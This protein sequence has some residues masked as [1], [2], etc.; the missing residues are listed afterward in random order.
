MRKF[1]FTIIIFFIIVLFDPLAL[2]GSFK[3]NY[4]GARPLAL[5]GAFVGLADD[6][7]AMLYNPAGI[8][9][10]NHFEAIVEYINPYGVD[11]LYQNTGLVVFNTKIFGAV[12]LGADILQYRDIYKEFA[13]ILSY[14]KHISEEIALGI[15]LKY[16]D[17]KIEGNFGS[18]PEY[19]FSQKLGV[20]IAALINVNQFISMGMTA[21]NMNKPSILKEEGPAYVKFGFAAYPLMF[22]SSYFNINI[23]KLK[24]KALV[25]T[26]D[27]FKESFV[28]EKEIY[29]K[30]I[31]GIEYK[32]N[33]SWSIRAG[34][35]YT[36]SF[37][38]GIGFFVKN[39]VFNYCFISQRDVINNNQIFSAGIKL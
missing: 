29:T 23:K 15:N 24:L 6:V 11:E 19:T 30:I 27:V 18:I 33:Q 3:V 4:T 13:Y 36:R 37:S 7:Y 32:V 9:N 14:G 10:I 38:L 2:V 28:N 20:D 31:S 21:Y 34:T 35:D 39:I 12:G 1:K 5:G 16:F 17:R 26:I 8:V 22:L 25:L